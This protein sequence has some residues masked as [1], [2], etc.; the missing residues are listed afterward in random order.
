MISLLS[1]ERLSLR[2]FTLQDTAFII[3]LLNSPGW[4]QFIGDRDV[5]SEEDAKK[6]LLNGPLKSYKENGFGLSMVT[7]KENELPIGMCGL[8]KRDTLEHPDLG[9]AFLP[10]FGGHGYAFEIAHALLA[11]AKNKWGIQKISAITLP[12]N[13][14]SIRL[15]EKLGFQFE[16]KFRLAPD[17]EELHLYN[18]TFS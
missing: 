7:L 13:S 8:L 4:L 3:K 11:F 5:H 15:L 17:K 2:E 18:A 16:S 6:Y 1:T 14:K 12:D 10:Q 9:F